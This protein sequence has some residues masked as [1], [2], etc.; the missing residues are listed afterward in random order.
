MTGRGRVGQALPQ[1]GGMLDREAAED[2]LEGD[3][4]PATGHRRRKVAGLN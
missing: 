1:P 2:A 4:T 3:S